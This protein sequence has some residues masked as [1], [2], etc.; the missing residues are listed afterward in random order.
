MT[1]NIGNDE[2]GEHARAAKEALIRRI[3]QG[4]NVQVYETLLL[5]SC[6]S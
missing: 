6:A 3:E 4:G 2:Q 1:Q 5:L